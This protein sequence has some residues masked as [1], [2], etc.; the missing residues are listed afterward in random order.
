MLYPQRLMHWLHI[1]RMGKDLLSW[2][3]KGQDFPGSAEDGNPLDN[4]GDMGS[5]PGLGRF[6]MLQGN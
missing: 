3:K 1:A 5:I 4:A 2:K 6:H